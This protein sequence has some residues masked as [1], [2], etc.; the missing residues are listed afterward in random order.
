MRMIGGEKGWCDLS[1]VDLNEI[2]KERMERDWAKL[3]NYAHLTKKSGMVQLIP[4][5]SVQR[6]LFDLLT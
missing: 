2:M 3:I 4:E 5:P 1:E 6:F